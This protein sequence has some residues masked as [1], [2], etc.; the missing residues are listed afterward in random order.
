MSFPSM[1]QIS[2]MPGRY[3]RAR[4]LKQNLS[5]GKV[6]FF[7]SSFNQSF[8]LVNGL[9]RIVHLNPLSCDF[10]RLSDFSRCPVC[11]LNYETEETFLEHMVLQHTAR[12]QE[13]FT[14]LQGQVKYPSF[15]SHLSLYSYHRDFC[16]LL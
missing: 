13:T 8:E 2:N 10:I 12:L 11:S 6:I 16:L 5:T 4:L 3:C 1:V 7:T 9:F 15:L 14:R